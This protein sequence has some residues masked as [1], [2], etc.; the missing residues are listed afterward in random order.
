MIKFTEA[1]YANL[2]N[3][4]KSSDNDNLTVAHSILENLDIDA[5]I[6]YVLMLYKECSSD[7]RDKLFTDQITAAVNKHAVIKDGNFKNVDWATI[8]N[9]AQR[10]KDDPL[11][12]GFAISR[13]ATEIENQLKDAGF[14]FMDKYK[15]NLTKRHG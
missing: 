13:F 7:K 9:I 6:V 3:M 12:E 11:V 10:K 1:E 5:N 15:V 8:I 14:I 2:L 4:V